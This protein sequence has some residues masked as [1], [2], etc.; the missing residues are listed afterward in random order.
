M[1]AYAAAENVTLRID[2]TET[3]VRR[4]QGAL[5]RQRAFISGKRKQNTITISDG[6]GRTP[7]SGAIRPGGMHDQTAVR[8][9]GIAEQF[10]QHPTVSR[11]GRGL[12]GP[13][14][15]VPRPG[16]R[17][18]QETGGHQQRAADRMVRMA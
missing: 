11:G 18:A 2:G 8:T 15:R 10:R 17:S 1:F 3:Q 5:P 4:P 13:G 7:W 6:Q 14:Q 16:Q 12:Q 9:E